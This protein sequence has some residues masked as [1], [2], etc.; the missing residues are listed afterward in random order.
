VLAKIRE[1]RGTLEGLTPEILFAHDQDHYGGLAANDAL[2]AATGIGAGQ[3][4]LDVCAGLGGPARYQAWRYGCRVIGVD[5]NPGRVQGARELTELVHLDEQVAFL[6]G[7]AQDLPFT[8]ASFDVVLSQEA[9]LHLADKTR[10]VAE[11]FRVLRPGGRFA[12]TDWVAGPGFGPEDRA[13]MWAGV[14][15]RG[16]PTVWDYLGVLE[17]VGFA[18][19]AATDLSAA[20]VPILRDRLAMYET[21]RADAI[22]RTGQDPHRDYCR[23]YARFVELAE[24]GAIGGARFVAVK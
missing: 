22:R 19:V 15:A 11:A 14:A 6:Y 23:F 5:A 9:F 17:D 10:G 24:T 12:F 2:A 3:L 21:L 7:D 1:A 16:V 8:A 20:W 18:G 13:V 4:V